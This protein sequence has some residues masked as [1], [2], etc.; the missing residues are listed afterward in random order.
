MQKQ[1]LV[2]LSLFTN[3]FTWRKRGREEGREGEGE[4]ERRGER[5]RE[6]SI[7]KVDFTLVGWRVLKKSKRMI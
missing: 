1:H 7:C 5:E 3:N 2:L 4:K 6:I